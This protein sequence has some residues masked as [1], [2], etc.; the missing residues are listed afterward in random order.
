MFFSQIVVIQVHS[1]YRDQYS[2][3]GRTGV[4]KG[5]K[6][7]LLLQLAVDGQDFRVADEGKGQDGH[8]V[9]C[10]CRESKNRQKP[11]R[12]RQSHTKLSPAVCL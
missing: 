11:I 3:C 2:P 6:R 10:L 5:N 7:H 1:T 9:G 8:S 4:F 12:K